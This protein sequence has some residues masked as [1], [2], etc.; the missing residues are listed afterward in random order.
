MPSRS[1]TVTAGTESF[2]LLKSGKIRQ[3]KKRTYERIIKII[4]LLPKLVNGRGWGFDE[5][6][7]VHKLIQLFCTQIPID[8]VAGKCVYSRIALVWGPSVST[9]PSKVASDIPI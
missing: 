7:I 3:R 6:V 9:V 1:L 2:P 5:I 4:V 8:K